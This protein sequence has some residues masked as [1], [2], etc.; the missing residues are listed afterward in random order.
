MPMN[1]LK[2]L[3]LFSLGLF[4]LVFFSATVLNSCT[5]GEKN[6]ENTEQSTGEEHSSGDAEHPAGDDEHPTG[7]DE[8]PAGDDEHPSDEE[9][10]SSDTTAT[11]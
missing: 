5:G 7:G 11:E 10:P 3:K 1:L 4:A 2:K 9:H 8:H 6:K